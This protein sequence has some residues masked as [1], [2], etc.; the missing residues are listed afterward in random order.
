MSNQVLNPEKTRTGTGRVDVIHG[1]YA[2]SLPLAGMTVL[3]ARTDL[4]ERM[5]IDPEAVAVIDGEEAD[6]DTV[7][8][9]GQ[10]LNFV[11]AAGEK[12]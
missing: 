11:A 2:H 7:L 1:I 6:D 4:E 5:N 10:V 9:E 3:Q 12:G 8:L